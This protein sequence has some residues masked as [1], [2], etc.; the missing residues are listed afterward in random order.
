M[1]D[2]GEEAA[3]ELVKLDEFAVGFFEFLA[4]LIELV[5]KS[6]FA[7]TG[8]AVKKTTNH[9]YDTRENQKI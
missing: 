9:N 3:L 7:V 1:A 2:V 8:F 4:A 6:E 5:T